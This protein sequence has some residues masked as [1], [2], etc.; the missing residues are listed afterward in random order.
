MLSFVHPE[1]PN[2]PG[3][4]HVDKRINFVS[5]ALRRASITWGK[6]RTSPKRK[7]GFSDYCPERRSA[8]LV[9]Q[10]D[11]FQQCQIEANDTT[12]EKGQ[13]RRSVNRS[14]DD[15]RGQNHS[16][17]RESK[18]STEYRSR[19]PSASSSRPYDVRNYLGI[20]Q[21]ED[22]PLDGHA[23]KFGLYRSQV[24]WPSTFLPD[25]KVDDQHSFQMSEYK[26]RE[27]NASSIDV[28]DRDTDAVRSSS[29]GSRECFNGKNTS[30]SLYSSS[31]LAPASGLALRECDRAKEGANRV[32]D[33]FRDLSRYDHH[34]Y[35]V[36][37][38]NK[39]I[40]SG[41]VTRQHKISQT[42]PGKK[43][44]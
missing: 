40:A 3:L 25:T 10:N 38:R 34:Q 15:N 29:S 39:S 37:R 19:N 6:T 14:H 27:L 30:P 44:S 12:D 22:R 5:P 2:W 1:D 7:A 9:S 33:L 41:Y 4:K 20:M 13:H 11:L 26:H 32:L 43:K 24:V 17:D 8:P 28:G 42:K 23:S 16:R 35:T 18:S 36:N 21:P 31:S